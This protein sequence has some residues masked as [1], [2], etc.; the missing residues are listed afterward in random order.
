LL[1]AYLN[2]M[3]SSKQTPPSGSDDAYMSFPDLIGED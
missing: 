3:I 2:K 1:A